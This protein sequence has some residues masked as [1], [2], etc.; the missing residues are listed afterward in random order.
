MLLGE[1][2]QRTLKAWM[3]SKAIIQCPT[4][5]E[6][7]WRFATASYL[8]ELLEERNQDLTEDRGW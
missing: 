1:V 2:Q 3:R 5:G 8:R 4:C 6:D 7:R